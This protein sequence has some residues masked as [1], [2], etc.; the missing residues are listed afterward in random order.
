V[1]QGRLIVVWGGAGGRSEE[2]WIESSKQLQLFADEIVLTTDDPYDVD[3]SYIDQVIRKHIL[4]E[5]GD[6][7][8]DIPDRYEAIRYAILTAEN[9]DTVLVAGR[10][11][12]K[13]QTIGKTK[14]PFEDKNVCQEILQLMQKD[15]N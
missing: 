14:I 2:N 9:D 15:T 10:G 3:P 5:E 12:E 11:H 7:F 1:S 4:R 13:I 8:F 6:G